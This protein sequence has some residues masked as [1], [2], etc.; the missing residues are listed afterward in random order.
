MAQVP[1]AISNIFYAGALILEDS[2]RIEIHHKDSMRRPLCDCLIRV[3]EFTTR[4]YEE[5]LYGSYGHIV[6]Y[7]IAVAE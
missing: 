4:A 5:L 2:L 3:G 6:T 1:G 7:R